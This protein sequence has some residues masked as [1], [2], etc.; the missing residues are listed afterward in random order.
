MDDR[1]YFILTI[2]ANAPVELSEFIGALDSMNNQFKKHIKKS[3]PDLEDSY[4]IYVKE[5]RKGSYVVEF[6]PALLPLIE[7]IEHA[8]IVC[9]FLYKWKDRLKKYFT[10]KGRDKKASKS[11]LQDILKAVEVIATNPNSSQ[12]LDYVV[13]KDGK[14]EKETIFKFDTREANQARKE[15][16]DHIIE[17]EA[18]TDNSK[19]RAT[20]VFER[21]S[22]TDASIGKRSGERVIIEEIDT[23]PRPLIYASELSE[24]QI[25][26]ELNNSDDNPF[27]KAFIVDVNIEYRNQKPW[28]YRVTDVHQI[29]P[30]DD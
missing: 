9:D 19:S 14:A 13:H 29:I 24:R 8:D 7:H 21:P 22:S 26:H 3:A 6:L 10:E 18:I 5:V 25:K 11:D 23:R 15:I 28:A 2:D 30:L 20:M 27:K 17:I 4:K 1:N 12:H 16:K